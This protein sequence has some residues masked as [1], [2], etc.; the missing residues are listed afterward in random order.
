MQQEEEDVQFSVWTWSYIEDSSDFVGHLGC[1]RSI[2]MASEE[3][4]QVV[5]NSQLIEK[6]QKTELC[7]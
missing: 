2:S 3:A 4:A 5:G 1:L 7:V 6:P